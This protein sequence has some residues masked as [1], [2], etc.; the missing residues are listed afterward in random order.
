MVRRRANR[1]YSRKKSFTISAIETGAAL[2]LASSA[3]VDTA[4]KSALA[5]NLAGALSTIQTSVA[6]NKTKIIG[7]LGAAFVGKMIAKSFGNG[8]LAKLGPIRI[9]A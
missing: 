1:R 3:G 7:T 9:K 5:G 6:T 8:Q 2:S 4:I